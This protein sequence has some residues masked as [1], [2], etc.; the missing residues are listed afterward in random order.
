MLARH[1]VGHLLVL[2]VVENDVAVLAAADDV[3][4]VWRHAKLGVVRAQ[5]ELLVLE[6]LQQGL[7]SN[8]P[9]FDRVEWSEL[10]TAD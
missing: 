4:R 1:N 10:G 6:S 2:D 7:L 8:I 9:H 5:S 3:L